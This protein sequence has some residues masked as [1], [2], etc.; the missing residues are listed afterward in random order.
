MQRDPNLRPTA[1][2]LLHHPF[3]DALSP[4]D[5]EGGGSG[6]SD[7]WNRSGLDAIGAALAA[8]SSGGGVGD[9]RRGATPWSLPGLQE[10]GNGL[11]A[12]PVKAGGVV[13]RVPH[14][15]SGL[16]RKSSAF[17]SK[18]S[19][20][21]WSTSSGGDSHGSGGGGGGGEKGYGAVEESP[22]GESP[23]QTRTGGRAMLVSMRKRSG[24]GSAGRAAALATGSPGAKAAE[25][26]TVR[27]ASAGHG[28]QQNGA[29]GSAT[30]PRG[31]AFPPL[32]GVGGKDEGQGS[33]ASGMLAPW[34]LGKMLL[35]RLG[36]KRTGSGSRRGSATSGHA[37]LGGVPG[38]DQARSA[39][40]AGDDGDDGSS[41]EEAAGLAARA[42]RRRREAPRAPV[43]GGHLDAS[44]GSTLRSFS[45][46]RS[47]AEQRMETPQGVPALDL[48]PLQRPSQPAAGASA[49]EGKPSKLGGGAT[50]VGRTPAQKQFLRLYTG[51]PAGDKG[52]PSAGGAPFGRLQPLGSLVGAGGSFAR[53]RTSQGSSAPRDVD[54]EG[55]V[56][57][58]DEEEEE[59]D[60]EEEDEE[61]P[62][63]NESLSDDGYKGESGPSRSC[64]T[65]STWGRES[66]PG[67]WPEEAGP[68][69]A[70]AGRV[71]PAADP[72]IPPYA[73]TATW[74][75]ALRQ[76]PAVV[77]VARWWLRA[78]RASVQA[79]PARGP[80]L[81]RAIG[82]HA[83]QQAQAQG[84]EKE[85]EKP[86]P[87]L[88]RSRAWEGVSADDEAET[89]R[90]PL[91]GTPS[92]AADEGGATWDDAALQRGESWA[93]AEP[94]GWQ[95]QRE[96]PGVERVGG[97]A[98]VRVVA[99]LAAEAEG[100]LPL[101]EGMRLALVEK[102]ASG[103]WLGRVVGVPLT[104]EGGGDPAVAAAAAA[105]ETPPA[106]PSL[107]REGW[108]P[109]TYVEWCMPGEASNR[110]WVSIASARDLA[111]IPRQDRLLESAVLEEEVEEW[112]E[113]GSSPR[114]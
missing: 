75:V 66:P 57:E 69:G 1:R 109:C 41:D 63:D 32:P 104:G 5:E 45:S 89:A 112:A 13:R 42:G 19:D 97:F 86:S 39:N 91:S 76:Q 83:W 18:E 44:L 16:R 46:P 11:T 64:A 98:I 10:G 79:P 6:A 105:T 101:I 31:R 78:A 68:T 74:R 90:S 47:T 59:E 87:A 37:S 12:S 60:K 110:S 36:S 103:W 71:A 20:E 113:G 34:R 73:L 94:P 95:S 100:E 8:S 33:P 28:I 54:V 93:S 61:E 106:A 52:V 108:F 99:G 80:G 67:F 50:A 85:E 88:S 7:D 40:G 58:D 30:R 114:E 2:E 77:G 72:S 48:E 55:G 43:W 15:Q 25:A 102:D 81:A 29:A 23:L 111:H 51:S 21:E 38:A 84:R 4:R 22:L 70:G 65:A 49:A 26:G 92:E 62:S 17:L 27:R 35:R 3:L 96:P 24:T 56:K 9:H 82:R 14:R 53:R 107:L